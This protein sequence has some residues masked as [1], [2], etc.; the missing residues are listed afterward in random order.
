MTILLMHEQATDRTNRPTKASC[1]G[2]EWTKEKLK[3]IGSYLSAYTTA[4][5]NQ[6]FSKLYIDAFAGTGYFSPSERHDRP[7]DRQL[8]LPLTGVSGDWHQSRH[9]SDADDSVQHSPIVDQTEDVHQLFDGSARL[10]LGVEPPFDK[11]VFVEI[12]SGK[13]RRLEE[14]GEEFSNRSI[15]VC[16]GD[17]NDIVLSLCEKTDW[18]KHRAVLFLD[19]YGMEVN[20]STVEA[21]AKTKSIDMWLLFPM[22]AVSISLW[23]NRDIP[24]KLRKKLDELLGTPYWKKDLLSSGKTPSLWGQ[25]PPADEKA[26][27]ETVGRYFVDRLKTIFPKHGVVE[28]GVLFNSKNSPLFLLC[29]AAGNENGAKIASRIA[30][31]CLKG[32]Q[33][34]PDGTS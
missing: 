6:P 34:L 17:A 24:D 33:K 5:K 19:P 1:F 27:S 23:A 18:R 7:M 16:Q 28:P 10:A 25:S 29:F 30:K 15:S 11:Y 21:V 8:E 3:V 32:L 31:S 13:C 20:W 4:L 14:L 22:S 2:G 9:S 26:P 12:D